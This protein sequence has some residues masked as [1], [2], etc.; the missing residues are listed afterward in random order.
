M[1]FFT[2]AIAKRRSRI[3]VPKHRRAH[4]PE[5]PRSGARA[6]VVTEPIAQTALDADVPQL[7][8][9]VGLQ[10]RRDRDPFGRQH[11][12]QQR[13]MP[14]QRARVGDQPA[15]RDARLTHVVA[16]EVV[17]PGSRVATRSSSESP[18]RRKTEVH[19]LRLGNFFQ[20]EARQQPTVDASHQLAHD[21]AEGVIVVRRARTRLEQQR[22]IRNAGARAIP[23]DHHRGVETR[24][25]VRHTGFVRQHVAHGDLGFAVGTELEASTLHTGAS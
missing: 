5:C 3:G 17:V 2:N 18:A 24:G 20:E 10:L 13:V 8:H 4:V 23:V 11:P 21:V 12:V 14:R 15:R 22:Q 7:V 1:W 6:G 9:L 16:V 19:S 25:R